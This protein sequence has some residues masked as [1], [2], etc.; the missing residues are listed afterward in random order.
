MASSRIT[1]SQYTQRPGLGYAA[2][3]LRRLHL[4]D[5]DAAAVIH[6]AAFDDRL[7][8]LAGLHTPEEDRDYFRG[9]VFATCAVWGAMHRGRLA[10]FIAFREA[11]VDQL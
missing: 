2:A 11:W 7:P 6:R 10:G 1:H 3:M 8:W 5:M 9:R 4:E